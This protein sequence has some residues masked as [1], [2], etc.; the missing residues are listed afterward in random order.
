MESSSSSIGTITSP[1]DD[2]RDDPTFGTPVDPKHKQKPSNR[3]GRVPSAACIAVQK[4]V[5]KTKG[6]KPSTL[7]KSKLPK[8]SKPKPMPHPQCSDNAGNND[9]T[10]NSKSTPSVTMKPVSNTEADPDV[11]KPPNVNNRKMGLKVTHHGLIRHGPTIKRHRFQC[12]MCCNYFTGST[13]YI[14]HYKETHPALLCTNCEK[15]F[16]N[17]LSL[18]KHKYHHQESVKLCKHCGRSFAFDCQLNDHLKTHLPKKLHSCSYANCDRS[19]TH[20]YDLRKHEGTH[21]KTVLSCKDCDYKTKDV[22]NLKQQ[23][24]IHTGIKPYSCT[25]CDKC[26]TFFVQK[27]RH[28]C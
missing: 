13:Y 17:P 3:P 11:S 15:V 18:K 23:E 27:K 19:F 22:Q 7:L 5:V 12:D 21:T 6:L 2:E 16:M 4:L 28:S 25:K 8:S 24:R 10:T 26:F 14:N 1:E 9:G 20:K